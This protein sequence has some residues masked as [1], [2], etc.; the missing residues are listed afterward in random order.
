MEYL[1]EPH[2]K[3]DIETFLNREQISFKLF[4]KLC[5]KNLITTAE[6]LFY[7]EDTMDFKNGIYLDLIAQNSEKCINNFKEMTFYIIGCGG[8]GNF[9]SYAI[10][11][12]SPKKIIL[13]DGDKIEKSNLNRQVLF[14]EEHIGLYKAEVIAKELS[15]RNSE[16]DIEV[17]T[18]YLTEIELEELKKQN[19]ESDNTFGILS[20]DDEVATKLASQFFIQYKVPFINIGYLNDISV[21]GPFVIP[22]QTSCPFCNS[23]FSINGDVD[24]DN[25]V[26]TKLFKQYS[27]PSSFIN[28][29]LAASLAMSDIVQ[30]VAGNLEDIKSI[31]SR[32]GINSSTFEKYVLH[33]TK[34]NNCLVCGDIG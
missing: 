34:D 26:M 4:D 10:S 16:L 11:T 1:L 18:E 9:M 17:I 15:K 13:V 25:D 24:K 12:F 23:A 20:G 28:N 14:S 27:A 7:K 31:D 6:E 8:I 30:F 29:S 3:N 22:E 33:N 21:I 32:V 5:D 2:D 19:I